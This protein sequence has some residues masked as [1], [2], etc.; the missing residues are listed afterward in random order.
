MRTAAP[1]LIFALVV[2]VG[3]FV[4]SHRYTGFRSQ[5]SAEDRA[6][7]ANLNEYI[8]ILVPLAEALAEP[9]PMDWRATHFDKKQ[10]FEQYTRSRPVRPRGARD[11]IYVQPLGDFSEQERMIVELTTA[12]LAS[13]FNCR[14]RLNDDLPSSIIPEDQRRLLPATGH[15]QVLSG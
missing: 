8:E 13:Y 15:E 12:F 5:Q 7:A 4:V 6:R 3:F 14:V 10:T 11:T 9:G 1:L 2:V